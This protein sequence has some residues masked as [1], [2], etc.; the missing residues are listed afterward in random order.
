MSSYIHELTFRETS[1]KKLLFK[2]AGVTCAAALSLSAFSSCGLFTVNKDRDM[3]RT[4]ATVQID[5]SVDAE[6][7][8]KREITAGYVSY[9]YYYVQKYSYT[10]ADAYKLVF[11]NLIQNSVIVQQSRKE[12]IDKY[13][14]LLPSEEERTTLFNEL[15]EAGLLGLFATE[16]DVA[17]YRSSGKSSLNQ[18]MIDTYGA[19]TTVGKNDPAF[20]FA[21]REQVWKAISDVV[22]SI[23]S[24]IDS[25]ADSGSQIMEYISKVMFKDAQ[26]E[27][28]ASLG[29]IYF[30]VVIVFVAV[31]YACLTPS[32][33]NV[34]EN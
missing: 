33:R 21:T 1:M 16:A 24:V 18:Y 17:A 34:S 13:S 31:A 20:R 23:N 14:S 11:N 32:I 28:A 25:F 29:W 27:Y 4:A 9:G 26:F 8:Y 3:A 5:K 6:N 10:V 2:L 7:I 19:K 30:A 15:K 12:L 22:D